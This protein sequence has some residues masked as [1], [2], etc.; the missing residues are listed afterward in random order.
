M[1]KLLSRT[2]WITSRSRE[3]S[4][5]TRITSS[6]P[7]STGALRSIGCNTGRRPNLILLDLFLPVMDGWELIAGMRARPALSAIPI[8]V[9]TGAGERALTSAPVSAGYLDKTR[10]LETL[11]VCLTRAGRRP[12]GSFPAGA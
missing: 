6:R 3:R 1:S 11:A 9:I 4:S 5:R 12:S 2:T 10:L 8:V 7:P